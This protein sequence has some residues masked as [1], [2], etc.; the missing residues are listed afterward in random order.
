MAPSAKTELEAEVEERIKYPVWDRLTQDEIA[1]ID[2]PTISSVSLG[3]CWQ[4]TLIIL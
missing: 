1:N 2:S 3:I 4:M